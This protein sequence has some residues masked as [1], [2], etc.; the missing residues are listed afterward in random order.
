VVHHSL[1]A[2]GM[3]DFIEEGAE[4]FARSASAGTRLVFKNHPLDNGRIDFVSVIDRAAARYHLEERLFYLD[5]GHMPSLIRGA[6]GS[7]SQQHGRSQRHPSWR[8]NSRSEMGDL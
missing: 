7:L 1:F 6:R 3:S 5:G 2:G 8:S 4:P